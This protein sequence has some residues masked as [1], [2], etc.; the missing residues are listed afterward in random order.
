[1]NI[2]IYKTIFFLVLITSC[3]LY[4]EAFE[5]AAF[6]VFRS[7]ATVLNTAIAVPTVVE[8]P[9]ASIPI[10]RVGFLV[11]EIQ[12]G[13]LL[14]SYFKE[15][16][17]ESEEPVF[18]QSILGSRTQSLA[19][20]NST[21][22]V[23][24]PLQNGGEIESIDIELSSQNTITSSK[25][26]LEL[27]KNVTLP[28]SVQI[29]AYISGS[30]QTVVARR[31]VTSNTILFPETTARFWNVT[32]EYNQPLR[33]AELDLVQEDRATQAVQ[34]L[35]FL[36]QKGMSYN[37]FFNPDQAF[38]AVTGESGD[39]RNDTNVRIVQAS[40][41]EKNTLYVE[42]DVDYDGVKDVR[43]NCPAESNPG[44]EDVDKNG[45]GDACDDFDRDAIL[46]NVD[47]CVNNPNM[48]QQDEDGDGIGDVCDNEESRVTERY[49]WVPWVGMGIAFLV[50]IILFMLVG[51]KPKE[52]PSV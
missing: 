22:M 3:T 19:D 1:M 34:S 8:V 47:N 15:S 10:D 12:T 39:L 23:S 13:N 44:Q 52:T 28:L 2:S 35:R 40:K 6:S 5:D 29:T 33:I 48:N 50:L 18:A 38:T 31:P 37:I 27:G 51:T 24:V 4:T 32:F 21:T 20:N 25:L 7:K 43:D 14:P 26:V 42:A 16:R 46:N 11:Q 9:F 36:A 41:I 17:I 30:N 49:V 45:V